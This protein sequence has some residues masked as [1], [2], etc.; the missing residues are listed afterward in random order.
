MSAYVVIPPILRVSDFGRK[1]CRCIC[2]TIELDL[3]HHTQQFV[4]PCLGHDTILT[5]HCVYFF[6]EIIY[7]FMVLCEL[8]LENLD[9]VYDGSKVFLDGK[10]LM[11]LAQTVLQNPPCFPQDLYIC[12]RSLA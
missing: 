2:G 9:I 12:E 6:S 4:R 1:E 7:F 5:H 10:V 11:C 8:V 3:V